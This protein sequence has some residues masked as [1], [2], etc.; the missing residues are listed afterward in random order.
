MWKF[1]TGCLHFVFSLCSLCLCGEL[2]SL[3]AAD[4]PQ[5]LGT[6]RNGISRETGLLTSWS[7][8]GRPVLWEKSIGEG[9]SGPVVVGNKLVLFHRLGNEEV[10]ECLEA[11]TG[12]KLWKYSY[13]T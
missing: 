9:Y 2:L 1:S 10:V 3:L 11:D 7:E 6:E 5:F 4:W 8:K 12:K 13:P